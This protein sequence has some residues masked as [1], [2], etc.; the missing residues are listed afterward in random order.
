MKNWTLLVCFLSILVAAC[1]AK[2]ESVEPT[3]DPPHH[4][5]IDISVKYAAP[6][7]RAVKSLWESGDKVYV[8]ID[9]DESTTEAEYITL[10]YDGSVWNSQLSKDTMEDE[11]L[12]KSKPFFKK[13]LMQTDL[14]RM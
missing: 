3:V 8:F 6:D 2:N 7:T 14:Y 4:L 11:I 9:L 5:T 13:N 10:T 1:D 12:K